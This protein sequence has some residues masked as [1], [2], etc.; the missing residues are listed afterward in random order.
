MKPAAFVSDGASLASDLPALKA[1]DAKVFATPKAAEILEL[2]GIPAQ[3]LGDPFGVNRIFSFGHKTIHLFGFDLSSDGGTRVCFESRVFYTTPDQAAH[4]QML[5]RACLELMGRGATICV[6]GGG[7]FQHM[8]IA[9]MRQ[10]QERVLKAVYDMQVCPPTYEFF[11][12][13]SQA[14]KYRA[15]NGFTCIDMTF[16]PGPMYGFRDDGLPPGPAER[17]SMLHR[18]CV[19]GA[20]LLPTVRNTHVMQARAHVDGDVFPPDW[21]NDRPR[22]LYGP[23]FQKNGYR[24]LVSTQA[25]RDEINR[26]FSKPYTTITLREAEYWPNRNSDLAAWSRAARALQY[27][28]TPAIIVPD[29]HGRGINGQESFEPASWDVDLRLAL[30]ESAVL[31]LGVMNGPMVLPMF[32]V[33]PAPYLIFQKPD[34]TSPGTQE[35]FMQAQGIRPGDHYTDNGWTLWEQDTPENVERAVQSWFKQEKAA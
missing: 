2:A 7:M 34:E 32:A 20:R 15:E 11:S 35:A 1:L 21:T 10:A 12:F 33:E 13:L 27:R 14:E 29:T 8:A 6:H 5:L 18:I 22:F 19:S 17:Q 31:N 28:G 9:V 24:C 16:F 25:A 23:K 30:Y 4:A 26:R 3:V